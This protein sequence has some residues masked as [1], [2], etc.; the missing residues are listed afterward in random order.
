MN[1]YS[2]N[3]KVLR[4]KIKRRFKKIQ[5]TAANLDQP[6]QHASGD[7]ARELLDQILQ[8]SDIQQDSAV[9]QNS[10]ADQDFNIQHDSNVY[11]V[12]NFNITSESTDLDLK[13]FL[14]KWANEF[15]INRT[16]FSVLLKY[17]KT[18]HPELPEDYRTLL[19]TPRHIEKK[20]MG[21]GSYVHIGV[22]ENILSFLSS[23]KVIPSQIRLDFNIDGLPI[24]KNSIKNSFWL[25]LCKVN[26]EK[27]YVVGAFY[28]KYKPNFE[29]FL[30]PFVNEMLLLKFINYESKKVRIF[31][32]NTICDAPARAAT[33]GTK[34]YNSVS[35]CP[36]CIIK[37]RYLNGRMTYLQ[38]DGI[39]RTNGN[40]R[41]KFD[42]NYHNYSSPIEQLDIDMIKSFPLDY[43]HIVLLGVTKKILRLWFGNKKC[44][45]L[46]S[47]YM[48][49][50]ISQRLLHL[51]NHMPS[52]FQRP[53][54]SLDYINFYKGTQFRTFL[55][56]GGPFALKNIIPNAMYMNFLKLSIGINILRSKDLCISHNQVAE[57]LL[58]SFVIEFAQ[59]YGESHV[60]HNF[61]CLFHLAEEC[62]IQNAPLDDFSAFAFESFMTPVK[63]LIHGNRYPLEQLA[64]RIFEMQNANNITS[65]RRIKND[66]EIKVKKRISNGL[67]SQLIFKGYK[68]DNSL[69]NGYFLSKSIEIFKCHAFKKIEDNY[70]V[71]CEKFI[72]LCDFFLHPLKSSKL[73]IFLCKN[74]TKESNIWININE[75]D[76]KIFGMKLE[77]DPEDLIT[78][79]PLSRIE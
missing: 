77:N 11:Q 25:I 7:N 49:M 12:E 67:Y 66:T 23:S 34:Q 30:L 43:L 20:N 69:K 2:I 19:G 22:R 54:Q 51:N 45:G 76:R 52:E 29:E 58:K 63:E 68:F 57:K 48:K 28:D 3:K 59:I 60:V 9:H 50:K 74:N 38:C 14:Q 16:A 5:R 64:N 46:F 4:Q 72:D 75:I 53:I 36:K 8:D 21:N 33:C 17:L 61:H 10:D 35:G 79:F 71:L 6:L 31:I 26:K 73:F 32:K 18:K 15:N 41:E 27:I 40:F 62:S 13:S 55:L 1:I 78:F 65:T 56:Y 39:K 44:K 47:K 70:F 42:K 37:G 24:F